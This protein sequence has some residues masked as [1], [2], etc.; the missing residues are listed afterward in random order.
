MQQAK[1]CGTKDIAEVLEISQKDV[2][3]I[4]ENMKAE[5][6]EQGRGIQIIQLG[7]AYQMCTMPEHYEYICKLFE[8]RNK[9]NL[10]NAALEVLS[11]IAYNPK[12][13]RAQI[14]DVRGV[15]SDSV[16]AKL[17][18]WELIEEAG[19]LDAPGRPTMYVTT[20]EFLRTFGYKSIEDMPELPKYMTPAN[21][22]LT[23]NE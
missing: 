22:Q 4:I 13:T 15:N 9:P 20:N 16:V 5:F 17:V 6:E 12:I 21:E 3:N 23:I 8:N 19:R 11:I 1:K 7:K 18:D 14:E 2:Q 10:T